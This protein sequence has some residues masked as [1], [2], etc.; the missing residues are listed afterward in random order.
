MM[1]AWILLQTMVPIKLI[2]GSSPPGPRPRNII[3]PRSTRRIGCG[4]TT[5][6]GSIPTRSRNGSIFTPPV[7]SSCIIV[8]RTKP[9]GSLVNKGTWLNLIT[10]INHETIQ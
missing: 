10:K 8:I 1:K 4:S 3:I 7:A 2:N 6:P 9:G 5:T